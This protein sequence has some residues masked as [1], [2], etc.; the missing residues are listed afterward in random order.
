LE[1]RKEKIRP[2][3]VD[4]DIIKLKRGNDKIKWV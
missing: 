1:F 4:K 2:E 3:R